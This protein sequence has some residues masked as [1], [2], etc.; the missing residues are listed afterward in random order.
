MPA[1]AVP[2]PTIAPDTVRPEPKRATPP[3]PA[4]RQVAATP[5]VRREPSRPVVPD[6]RTEL[7]SAAP[8]VARDTVAQDLAPAPVGRTIVP[9]A[10]PAAAS[11]PSP[12]ALDPPAPDPEVVREEARQALA[13][14]AARFA[15]AVTS[16]R[17]ASTGTL[18]GQIL[19]SDGAARR[20]VDFVRTSKPTASVAGLGPVTVQDGAA[21]ADATLQLEWRGDFGVTRRGQVRVRLLAREG[22]GEWRVA[23]VQPL[24]GSPR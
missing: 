9:P 4:P 20:L 21:Q 11:V 3:D 19:A 8:T 22:E 2:A 18:T 23:G 7:A 13:R 10:E 16:A 12:L 17:T 6:R 24:D 5:D 14:G 1:D 15:A